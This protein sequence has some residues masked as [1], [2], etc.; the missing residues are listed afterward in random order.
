MRIVAM[1]SIAPEVG[2]DPLFLL[3]VSHDSSLDPQNY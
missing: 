2:K 3:E 1:Q